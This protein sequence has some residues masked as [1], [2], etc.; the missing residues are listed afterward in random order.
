MSTQYKIHYKFS[1]QKK[2]TANSVESVLNFE[3]G[4]WIRD[5][6]NV[7]E[8]DEQRKWFIPFHQVEYVE[9]V[10]V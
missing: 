5:D 9:R 6:F 2:D 7:A 8:T 4:F 10:N 3:R 1:N